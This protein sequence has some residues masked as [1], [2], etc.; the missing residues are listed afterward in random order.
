MLAKANEEE[1]ENPD[2]S[3]EEVDALM[4]DEVAEEV[5]EEEDVE[6]ETEEVRS[7]R[8]SCFK[9]ANV[10]PQAVEEELAPPIAATGT[11]LP[12][13]HFL[14]KPTHHSLRASDPVKSPKKK[15]K[16][17][18]A[19]PVPEAPTADVDDDFSRL[20]MELSEVSLSFG[21]SRKLMKVFRAGRSP[22]VCEQE[23]GR[24]T[25]I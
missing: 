6:M 1:E 10:P 16:S 2:E 19:A 17:R 23:G 8:F 12:P 25:V 22:E 11:K 3:R 24:C 14:S 7:F 18:N 20:L 5:V 9:A 4:L 21:A 15:H 13:R